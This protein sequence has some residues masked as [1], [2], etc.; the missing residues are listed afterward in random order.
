MLLL[1]GVIHASELTCGIDRRLPGFFG[2]TDAGGNG[3]VEVVGGDNMAALA[4]VAVMDCTS[5]GRRERDRMLWQ[6]AVHTS[7]VV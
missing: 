4:T 3:G 2:V 1:V 5:F 7:H 6:E